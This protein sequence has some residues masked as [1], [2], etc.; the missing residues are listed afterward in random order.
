MLSGFV[1]ELVRRPGSYG[2]SLA[3]G[4]LALATVASV[5][6]HAALQ[7]DLATTNENWTGSGHIEFS[8]DNGGDVAQ[9]VGFEF[10]ATPTAT[11]EIAGFPPGP[12]VFTEADITSISWTIDAS[13]NLSL[14]LK[15]GLVST[16]VDDA[17]LVL[18]NIGSST[19]SPCNPAISS[20]LTAF[21]STAQSGI[22]APG[23]LTATPA[24]TLP[25][26]DNDGV[27]DA[28]D[29]CP[30]TAGGASVDAAGCSDAQVDED[31]DGVCD[32]GAPS[33]GPSNCTGSDLC[34][35]TTGGDTVDSSGC[36]DAQVDEDGDGICDPGAPSGGPSNCSGSDNCPATPNSGQDDIDT[37]GEGDACDADDIQ[38]MCDDVT[39]PADGN[40]QAAASIDDGS[41]DPDGDAV[42]T[43]Q[44]PPGPYGLGDTGVTLTVDDIVTVGPDDSAAMCVATVTVVDQTD[45]VVA[46]NS[47]A[48]I[49]P[50]DAPISFTATATDNC[51]VQSVEITAFDCTKLTKKGK[52]IDKT[53]SCIVQLDGET[54]TIDDSGGVG[55]T[56]TWTVVAIDGSGNTTEQECSVDVVNPGK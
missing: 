17:G 55:T 39:V 21:C 9:V 27:A 41:F 43:S 11:G 51:S 38:A 23:V 2:L 10:T 35:G 37:D 3:A 5:P 36:S 46:C 12:V 18:Q 42:S 48:T 15:T 1:R 32:A 13:W 26:E 33:D 4:L 49:V 40:C 52:V 56:I 7:Q 29:L 16:G 50:P 45:P 8:V 34:P 54:I 44:S 28:D 6:A 47:P 25:D 24:H 31:A 22:F 20:D 19:G 30:G 53:E 14:F